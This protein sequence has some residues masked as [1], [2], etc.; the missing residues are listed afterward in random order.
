[1]EPRCEHSFEERRPA[2]QH[3]E[4]LLDRGAARRRVV[5]EDRARAPR[6]PACGSDFV[7]PLDWAQRPTSSWAVD[8]RCPECEWRGSGVYGQ[9]VL[10]RFD[11]ELDAGTAAVI[12]DLADLTRANMEEETDRF[13]AALR[14]RP[15]PARGLLAQPTSSARRPRRRRAR[16]AAAPRRE[17]SPPR[18]APS[19]ASATR[20]RASSRTRSSASVAAIRSQIAAALASSSVAQ[21]ELAEPAV[22][23]ARED[24]RQGDGAVE[25]VGADAPCRCARAGR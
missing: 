24:Q 25:Q 18:R 3:L 2:D 8:L 16:A 13:L 10:D 7:Y 23:L 17:P 4:S 12:D 1:M 5:A 6:L 19:F 14:A 9:E 20:A 11:I 15:R 22:G 21:V